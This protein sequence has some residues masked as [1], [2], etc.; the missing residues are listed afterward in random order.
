MNRYWI[1]GGLGVL[2][3]LVAVGLNEFGWREERKSEIAS[4]A[5][6]TQASPSAPSGAPASNPSAPTQSAP[7]PQSAAPPPSFDVVRINPAGDAVIAGRA[8]PNAE[9]T[10]LD[11]EKAIGKVIADGRGDWVLLPS[12]P[13]AP[14]SRSLTLTEKTADGTSSASDRAVVLVVPE[15]QKDIAG[16]PS[17]Q[18]AQALALSVP[19]QG[20]GPTQVLQVPPANIPAQ[21]SGSAASSSQSSTA[22]PSPRAPNAPVSAGPVPGVSVDVVDY[23]DAGRISFAGRTEPGAEVRLYLDNKLLGSAIAEPG[24]EWR[25]SP[26]AEVQPGLYTLRA[27]RVAPDGRVVARAELPLKRT[28]PMGDLTQANVV[29][30][31]PGNNLWSIARRVYGQGTQYTVIYQANQDQIRDPDLIYPGQV[32]QLPAA[33]N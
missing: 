2:L 20:S 29:V 18:P 1:I 12:S 16:R 10:V 32:F 5:P 11:G 17:D 26:S 30:I 9:V 8:A 23:D 28:A 31:Q 27:D 7:A 22:A 21:P 14:G 25:L 24:G 13:L 3:A 33:L 4:T 6:A 19:R 15:R